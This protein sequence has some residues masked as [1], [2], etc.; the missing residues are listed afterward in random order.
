VL[1]EFEVDSIFS[2]TWRRVFVSGGAQIWLL[3]FHN[4]WYS[5]G[6]FILEGNTIMRKKWGMNL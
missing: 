2:K 1:A 3:F 5:I 6:A 4:R